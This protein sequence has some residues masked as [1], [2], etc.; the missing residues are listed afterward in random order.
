M[1]GYWSIRGLGAPIRMMLSFAKVNHE[2]VLYDVV[3]KDESDW[4]KESWFHDK[5][6]LQD[7]GNPL[8]NLP[9]LIDCQEGIVL[10]Q[11]NAILAH[12]GNVLNMTGSTTSESAKCMELLCE[13][14][15]IRNSIVQF[16]YRT[17]GSVEKVLSLLKR[18]KHSFSKIEKHLNGSKGESALVDA[19]CYLVGNGATAPDFHLWEM[20]DQFQQLTCHHD[21]AE[22]WNDFPRLTHF[23][24]SFAALPLNQPYLLSF[25]ATKLPMNN[26][27]ACF[28]SD[29]VSPYK[30]QR[31]EKH[32]WK[33]NGEILEL[34]D[35]S[36]VKKRKSEETTPDG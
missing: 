21:Q 15:D 20:M 11:S 35:N 32:S 13:I 25:A 1:V 23:H 2:V 33:G 12:L 34:H 6:A 27:Y 18:S 16:V 8:M 5:K 30:Y 26:P 4:T 14:M 10:N 19:P 9:F 22:F 28:G 24:K 29:L 3:E 36:S 17:D 31:G 7:D